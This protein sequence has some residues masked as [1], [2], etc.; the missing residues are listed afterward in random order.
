M[1]ENLPPLSPPNEEV[2]SDRGVRTSTPISGRTSSN[3]SRSSSLVDDGNEEADNTNDELEVS[4]RSSS[5]SKSRGPKK[6][7]PI[8]NYFTWKGEGKIL[9]VICLLKKSDGKE[10]TYSNKGRN[11]TNM[12][13]HLQKYHREEMKEFVAEE[14]NMAENKNKQNQNSGSGSAIGDFFKPNQTTAGKSQQRHIKNPYPEKFQ[15]Y[16][17]FKIDLTRLAG[18]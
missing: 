14:K 11:T 12:K 10:C 1:A 17:T 7:S 9:A 5:Q 16:K 2:E 8:W 18:C 15:I 6:R 3:R 4:G 13:L